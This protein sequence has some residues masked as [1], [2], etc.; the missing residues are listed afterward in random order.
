[1]SFVNIDEQALLL[2]GLIVAMHSFHDGL[3]I[4]LSLSTHLR[5]TF[6]LANFVEGHQTLTGA[7]MGCA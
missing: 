4:A 1:M 6:A 3:W 5:G 7:R 2:E